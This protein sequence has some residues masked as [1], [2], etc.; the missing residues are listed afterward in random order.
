MNAG[1]IGQASGGAGHSNERYRR[2]ERKWHIFYV[3]PRAEKV[4]CK[5][6]QCL[7]YEVFLPTI[8]QTRIWKNRQRKEIEIPLF[9]NYIFVHTYDY[10]LFDIKLL[11]K[12]VNYIAW[13]GRPSFISDQEVDA[14]SRMLN[15]SVPLAVETEFC[16]G[17][18]VKIIAGP[19]AGHEGIL[20]RQSGKTRFGIE[21]KAINHTV[22][23]QISTAVLEKI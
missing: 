17:E 6:L 23:L 12:V 20:V 18:R 11:P 7:N 22:L 9:P 2:G 10:E 5:N 15:M 4:V 8:R 19:L 1:R 21:L 3:Y 16:T 14:I 13:E